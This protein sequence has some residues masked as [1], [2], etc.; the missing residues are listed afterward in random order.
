MDKFLQKLKDWIFP[1]K[2][3]HDEWV[4]NESERCYECRCYKDGKFTHTVKMHYFSP[5]QIERL[6][7][8]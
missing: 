1:P 3:T 4:N 5:E 8:C 7:N 6:R 2:F